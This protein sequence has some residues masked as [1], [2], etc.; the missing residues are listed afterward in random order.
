MTKPIL[1]YY[2]LPD[3]VVAFS[4]TRH[5]GV[6]KGKLAT[7][8]INSHHG[9][10]VAA[11]AENLQAVA[12]EI[13]VDADRIVRLHQIHETCCLPISEDFFLQPTTIQAEQAEGKDAVVTNCR[14]VCIGVHTADCV[15]ILF[16]DSVHHAVGAAHAGWRGTVK[17]IAQH[18]VRRMTELYD[19]EPKDLKVVIG[20]AISEKNFEVGQEVYDTFSDAGFSMED[21]ARMHDKWHIDLPLCNQLQLEEIGVPAYHIHQSGIC[22][23][24]HSDDFFSA[25]ILKDGFG[26]IYTGIAIPTSDS[27]PREKR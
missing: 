12:A 27:S 8:N 19:T 21:I 16:Y 5:G 10:D 24:D 17:R 26:T 6:S 9:D 23:Y 3:G 1:H 11:V 13:G 22:T 2:P 14:N 4:T 15:P 20:P 18:T 25:R 7:L